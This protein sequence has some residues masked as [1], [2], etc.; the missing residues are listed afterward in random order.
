MVVHIGLVR[1]LDETDNIIK[2]PTIFNDNA[3]F[4]ISSTVLSNGNVLIAYCNGGDN[5]YGYY[6]I[7]DN[8]GNVVKEPT[9]FSNYTAY[10][11]STTLLT[12]GNVA[13]SYQNN[14]DYNSTYNKITIICPLHGEIKQT[15][16][17]NLNDEDCPKCMASKPKKKIME[18]LD[19]YDIK[20]IYEYKIHGYNYTYDFFLSDL[21]I[22]IEYIGEQDYILIGHLDDDKLLCDTKANDTSKTN[23]AELHNHR[24][25]RI[26][27]SKYSTLDT[28]LPLALQQHIRYTRDGLY[29]NNFLQFAKYYNLPDDATSS[30]YKEYKFKLV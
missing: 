24:L 28:Y 8:N 26:Q 19:S 22:L 9:V 5:G 14:S 16:G 20:Y 23:L 15:I 10:F 13:I 21:N 30:D 2:S 7:L 11:I 18:L 1:I 27:H 17:N 25:I 12:N 3:T 6:V 4:F 29:F